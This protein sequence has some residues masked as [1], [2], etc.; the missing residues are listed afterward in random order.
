MQ[1][2]KVMDMARGAAHGPCWY[3]FTPRGQGLIEPLN[4][5]PFWEEAAVERARLPPQ[6]GSFPLRQESLATISQKVA[7]LQMNSPQH[8]SIKVDAK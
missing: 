4:N 1:K 5:S 7:G 6:A 8:D 2:L 3:R